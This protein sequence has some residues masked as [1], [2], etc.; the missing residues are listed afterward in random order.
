MF[1][2]CGAAEIAT[3]SAAEIA[4]DKW[5]SNSTAGIAGQFKLQNSVTTAN[6]DEI[7]RTTGRNLE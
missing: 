1:F 6:T 3:L 4:T 2:R 5:R 7:A